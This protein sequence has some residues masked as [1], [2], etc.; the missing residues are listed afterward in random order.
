MTP[1]KRNA[2]VSAAVVALL[3]AF[4]AGALALSPKKADPA[5]AAGAATGAGAGTAGRLTSDG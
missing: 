5:D 4:I 3:V 1:V 2:L